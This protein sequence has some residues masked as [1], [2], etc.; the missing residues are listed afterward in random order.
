MDIEFMSIDKAAEFLGLGESQTR[1]LLGEPDDIRITASGHAQ[2]LWQYAKITA[3]AEKR[4]SL[5]TLRQNN[6]GKRSCYQC[7]ERYSEDDLTGGYCAKCHAK[8]LVRNY[9]CNG[10][11]V[12]NIPSIERL[13]ILKETIQSIE[14]NLTGN[15]K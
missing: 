5:L 9:I 12:R 3:I 14:L 4:N 6:K 13:N 15:G 1:A 10:N 2:H 8:K 7:R 11:C